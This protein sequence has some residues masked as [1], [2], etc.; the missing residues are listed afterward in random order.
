M[1]NLLYIYFWAVPNSGN[2]QKVGWGRG[3]EWDAGWFAQLQGK[4]MGL[5]SEGDRNWEDYL[6]NI[7][8]FRDSI[9]VCAFFFG[10]GPLSTELLAPK[11]GLGLNKTFELQSAL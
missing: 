4:T 5:L 10:C 2:K 1:D 3:W 9:N 6:L 11:V 8:G 7:E